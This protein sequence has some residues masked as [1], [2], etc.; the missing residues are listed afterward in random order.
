MVAALGALVA[1]R[2]SCLIKD[3]FYTQCENDSHIYVSRWYFHG[4]PR[5]IAVDPYVPA[6]N[7][8]PTGIP[9]NPRDTNWAQLLEKSW[10]KLLRSYRSTNGGDPNEV[11]T[12]LTGAPN[13]YYNHRDKDATVMYNYLC[14]ALRQGRPVSLVVYGSGK[15]DGSHA[16]SLVS[17][18]TVSLNGKNYNLLR[19]FNPYNQGSRWKTNPWG[20]GSPNLTAVKDQIK[21]FT[22]ADDDGLVYMSAEDFKSIF[23][24]IMISWA[25]PGYQYYM[26]EYKF[27]DNIGGGTW[28]NHSHKFKVLKPQ[29]G[30]RY[31]VYIPKEPSRFSEYTDESPWEGWNIVVTDPNGKKTEYFIMKSGLNGIDKYPHTLVESGVEGEHTLTFTVNQRNNAIPAFPVVIYGVK[32]GIEFSD[33]IEYM[34]MYNED[35]IWKCKEPCPSGFCDF[36][37]GTCVNRM[38]DDIDFSLK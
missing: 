4:K 17:C 18:H 28:K 38:R 7:G 13:E 8:V 35:K 3:V 30:K 34:P 9:T 2:E 15:I 20:D 6:Y 27:D 22:D 32:G 37:W 23:E 21:D 11:M 12:A 10:S 33:P 19:Y 31:H 16:Y 24:L 25:T 1:V 36:G 26:K 29:V 5:I 14:D